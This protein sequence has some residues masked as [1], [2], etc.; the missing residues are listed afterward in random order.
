MEK[1]LSGIINQYMHSQTERHKFMDSHLS[2]L[3]KS[4]PPDWTLN[5]VS[6]T[7]IQLIKTS[8]NKPG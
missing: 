7:P 1:T 6:D 2:F 5:L 3:K 4:P 8:S